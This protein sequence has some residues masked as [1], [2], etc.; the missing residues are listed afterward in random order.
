FRKISGS[1]IL[2]ADDHMARSVYIAPPLTVDPFNTCQPFRE[3]LRETELRFDCPVTG[4]IDVAPFIIQTGDRQSLGLALGFLKNRRDDGC[5]LFINV[6]RLGFDIDR[7]QA[8][9]K[10]VGPIELKR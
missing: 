6:S 2:G 8:S 3:A 10:V 9:R 4:L 7:R 1:L 5:A